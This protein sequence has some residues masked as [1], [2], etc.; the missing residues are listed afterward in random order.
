MFRADSGSVQLV[1]T[2]LVTFVQC[3][4]KEWI[5]SNVP[6]I[7]TPNQSSH[8]TCPQNK[9]FF[10]ASAIWCVLVPWFFSS[11][12]HTIL[13]LPIR[14]LI[15]PSRQFGP[16]SIY[17]PQ[18][19]AIIVRALLLLPFWIMERRRPD[20]WAKYVRTPVMLLGISYIP[21][22]TGI[23]YSSWFAVG[24]VFQ[25]IIR[26]RDFAWWSKYNYVTGAALDCGLY[27]HVAISCDAAFILTDVWVM[28]R[29]CAFSA[30]HLLHAPTAQRW[31]SS[32]LV[33]QH[34]LHEHCVYSLH[35]RHASSPGLVVAAADWAAVPLVQT[36]PG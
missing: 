21:P 7:C 34:C 25:F 23:N 11:F 18:M 32:Q 19:Y 6:D 27:L 3:L 16:G 26:K 28:N 1:S 22:A 5:F 2:V 29:H 17:H 36:S 9:V 35:F 20:S 33:G 31:F 4:V 12:V 24:F 13:S 10:T 8:L 14:G 30:D 15:G